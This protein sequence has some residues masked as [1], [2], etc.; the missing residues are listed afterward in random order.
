MCTDGEVP[1][2]E[3]EGSIDPFCLQYDSGKDPTAYL[4]RNIELL[5]NEAAKLGTIS[6]LPATLRRVPSTLPAASTI[7]TDDDLDAAIADY[8]G[9]LQGVLFY[10]TRTR[11]TRPAYDAVY[12]LSVFSPGVL[13]EG[14]TEAD[15]HARAFASIDFVSGFESLAPAAKS[16]LDAAIAAAKA[17]VATTPAILAHPAAGRA[18]ARDTAMEPVTGITD[19][20]S[21]TLLPGV[22]GR[23]VGALVH[24]KTLP[25]AFTRTPNVDYEK[26]TVDLL[27]RMLTSKVAGKARILSERTRYAKTLATFRDLDVGNAAAGRAAKVIQ[28]EIAAAADA[29]ERAGLRDLL[30]ALGGP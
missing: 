5:S 22:R 12:W 20:I 4:A 15:V 17:W 27:E 29:T 23:V 26:K 2:A 1:S 3:A 11:V 21:S 10:F 7:V 18:A 6:S 16:A 30:A 13:P 25:F 9:H 24:S 28:G 19:W 14:F 8:V